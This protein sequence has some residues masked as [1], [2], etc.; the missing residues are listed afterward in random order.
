MTDKEIAQKNQAVVK[1]LNIAIE[2]EHKQH[3]EASSST[4]DS[5]MRLPEKVTERQEAPLVQ[6]D[7]FEDFA[8]AALS[9]SVVVK[10]HDVKLQAPSIFDRPLQIIHRIFSSVL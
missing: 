5:S 9:T 3:I 10:E 8:P 2:A 7:H 1:S 6:K 4:L